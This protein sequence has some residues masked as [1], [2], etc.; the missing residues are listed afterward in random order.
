MLTGR[1]NNKSKDEILSGRRTYLKRVGRKIRRD[2]EEE[3]EEEEEE[4]KKKNMSRRRRRR[5]RKSK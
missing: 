3:E 5:S 2:V 4:E 1:I